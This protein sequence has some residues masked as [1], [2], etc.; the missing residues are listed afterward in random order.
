[1]KTIHNFFRT[2]FSQYAEFLSSLSVGG[3]TSEEKTSLAAIMGAEDKTASGAG[4][5]VADGT[6]ENGLRYAQVVYV[7]GNN[8]DLPTNPK[9]SHVVGISLGGDRRTYL[10]FN[11]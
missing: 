6:G 10:H 11:K 3:L 9:F 5:W 8:N 2:D 1:M 7:G 4:N